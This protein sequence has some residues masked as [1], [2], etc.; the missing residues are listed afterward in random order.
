MPA[1]ISFTDLNINVGRQIHCFSNI[2]DIF[3]RLKDESTVNEI[4]KLFKFIIEKEFKFIKEG[5]LNRDKR[6]AKP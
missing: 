2:D 4:N 6:K 3:E 1:D 5:L